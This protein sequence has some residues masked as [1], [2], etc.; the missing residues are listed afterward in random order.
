M[1]VLFG[2]LIHHWIDRIPLSVKIGEDLCNFPRPT[3][4]NFIIAIIAFMVRVE[5]ELRE[6]AGRIK[7]RGERKVKGRNRDRE[8]KM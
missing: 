6:N 2:N 8:E 5:F 1:D 4:M 7:N 3:A